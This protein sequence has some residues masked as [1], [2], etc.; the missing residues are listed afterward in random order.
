ML[1]IESDLGVGS[2]R[3]RRR[4]RDGRRA[5]EFCLSGAPSDSILFRDSTHS[6]HSAHP[7]GASGTCIPSF[8][9]R[10][11]DTD[12]PTSTGLLFLHHSFLLLLS[13]TTLNHPPFGSSP[14]RRSDPLDSTI[15]SS[16]VPLYSFS[17]PLYFSDVYSP[18]P[19]SNIVDMSRPRLENHAR[20]PLSATRS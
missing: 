6:F 2:K 16:F 4:R 7:L 20:K 17:L 10:T 13:T 9:S 15:L 8:A 12:V 18:L 1:R 14:G 5:Y 3:R 11:P 19:T